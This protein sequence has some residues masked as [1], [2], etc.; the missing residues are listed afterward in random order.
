L[1]WIIAFLASA[2]SVDE[3]KKF[4]NDNRGGLIL[5]FDDVEFPDKDWLEYKLLK[6]DKTV[7]S[8]DPEDLPK[9]FCP[10]ACILVD[11]FHRKTVNQDIEWMLYFDYT[12][13]EEIYCWK[14]EDDKTGGEYE[15][16]HFKNRKIAS[17]HNHPKKLYSFPSLDNFDILENDFEDYEIICANS[18]FW[19]IEFKGILEN[20]IRKQIISDLSNMFREVNREVTLNFDEH[21]IGI[22]IDSIYSQYMINYLNIYYTN[23]NIKKMEYA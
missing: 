1:L 22:T 9:E 19:I 8:I 6:S 14:G 16:I 21:E 10:K 18:S 20:E 15:K 12:T 23:V 2:F 7:K 5:S 17:L 11:E 4:L 3:F 13:G